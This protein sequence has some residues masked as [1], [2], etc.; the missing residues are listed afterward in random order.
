MID[1]KSDPLKSGWNEVAT[2]RIRATMDLLRRHR[3]TLPA[4]VLDIGGD[5]PL[6][7][8][9]TQEFGTERVHTHH[10]LDVDELEGS[11]PCI[12]CFEVIEHLGSPL[13]L[14]QQIHDHLEEGGTAFISTPLVYNRLRPT[15]WLRG[16]HHIFEMD[17]FQLEFILEKAGFVVEEEV[18]CRYLDTWKYFT[19]L[20]PLI[21][22][23]TDRCVIWKLKKA[24]VA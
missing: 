6:G 5:S 14:M 18:L 16:K 9:I 17:R 23:F 12:F 4:R 1:T 21:K 19:G 8:A 22:F 24:G 2:A 3:D 11:W 15:H 10:D 13:R 20:R 7:Q